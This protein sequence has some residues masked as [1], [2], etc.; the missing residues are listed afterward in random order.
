MLLL[1]LLSKLRLPFKFLAFFN[2]FI[3]LGG[4]IILERIL[5]R[6]RRSKQIEW[7]TVTVTACLLTAACVTHMPSWYTYGIKPY[8]RSESILDQI[9]DAKAS[10]NRIMSITFE[11]SP[12][13]RYWEEL[14]HNLATIYR[15]PSLHGYDPLVSLSPRFLKVTDTLENQPLLT[16]QEYGV[17]YL[18]TPV[19]FNRPKL[20]GYR[21]SYRIERSSQ[22]P[23]RVI[24]TLIEHSAPVFA[25][26]ETSIR[27]IPDPLPLAFPE[28][29]PA[30]SLPLRLRGD[31]FDVDTSSLAEGGRVVANFLWYPEM[32]GEVNGKSLPVATDSWQRI[33]VDLPRPANEIRIRFVP[34]W[35]KGF[36]IGTATAFAGLLLGH[37][38]IRRERRIK[39]LASAAAV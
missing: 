25:D 5:R 10:A 2:I 7:C 34:R 19:D 28:L 18:L 29:H 23:W 3:V 15:V 39:E 36:A 14:P 6:V 13:A 33:I 27:R 22:I 11:R 38:A 35:W 21:T 9:P 37:F 12:S 17:E 20:S 24:A 8:P 4:A 30:V 26:D 32:R 31:G 1:P 16:L